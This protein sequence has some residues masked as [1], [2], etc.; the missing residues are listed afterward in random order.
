[1]ILDVATISKYVPK[2]VKPL[3]RPAYDYLS[4]RTFL[5]KYLTPPATFQIEITTYCNLK[6]TGCYRTIHKYSAKNKHMPLEDFKLYI[7]QLPR[8]T[9]IFLNGVG[10][11]MLHP[12]I[13]EIV[14]Y[15]R[16]SGR[17][18]SIQ[19]VTNALACEPEKYGELYAVGLSAVVVS[20]DSLEPQEI[21][22]LRPSTDVERLTR[23]IKYLTERFPGKISFTTVIS[24]QNL[25]T[26]MSTIK[27]LVELGAREIHCQPFDDMGAASL[28]LSAPEKRRF[29]EK[30]GEIKYEGVKLAASSTFG[31]IDQPCGNGRSSVI[32]VDGYLAPC[33]RVLDKDVF[34]LGNLKTTTIE[35]IVSSPEVR[36]LWSQVD[37]GIY[38]AF[39]KGCM[40]NHIEVKSSR[41][42]GMAT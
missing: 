40:L 18:G 39:C 10:E 8:A 23:T 14:K 27:R 21:V 9:N 1:M 20:V 37:Q 7:Q 19:F 4:T 25:D 5:K 15:A 35:K 17:I 32:T 22:Q 2:P 13:R 16:D 29:L 42:P 31:T 3:L 26:F 41:L 34:T 30:F 6:C 11:P 24:R 28:C 36:L 38:P 33:C 12:D